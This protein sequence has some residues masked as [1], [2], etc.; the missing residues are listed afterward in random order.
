M[1]PLIDFTTKTIEELLEL[2]K[3][4]TQKLY[5]LNGNNPIYNQILSLRDSVQAE[6]HERMQLQI[7]K[8]KLKQDKAQVLEIGEIQSEVIDLD[9]PDEVKFINSVAQAYMDKHNDTD[10][11]N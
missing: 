3:E 10:S 2:N 1:N 6:Y 4:Y 9:Q 11:K 5:N 7:H 8:D